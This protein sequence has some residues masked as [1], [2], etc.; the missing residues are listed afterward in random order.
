MVLVGIYQPNYAPWLGY[1][2]KMASVDVFVFLDDCQM[3]LGRSYVSRVQIRGCNGGAWLSVPVRRSRGDS[4]DV[5]RFA[6][7]RWPK[8]HL[9]T[10]QKTYGRCPYFEEVMYVVGPVYDDPGELLA[11]FNRRLILALA[12]YLGITPEFRVA[13]TLKTGNTGTHHLV[14]IVLRTGGNVY[15]SGA[16]GSSYQDPSAFASHGIGLDIRM[17]QAI[18]YPQRHGEFVPGLSALDAVFHLGKGARR[19]LRYPHCPDSIYSPHAKAAS[20]SLLP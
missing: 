8:R 4:I 20:L 18:F 12:A 1:F 3:P 14:E 17:Y 5:V 19:L 13:S 10:L 6:D 16:G 15:V 11:P 9:A 2:A 7:C